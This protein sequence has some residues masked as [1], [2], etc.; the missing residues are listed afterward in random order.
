M[1]LFRMFSKHISVLLTK[2]NITF[3]KRLITVIVALIVIAIIFALLIPM[4]YSPPTKTYKAK[5]VAF[6]A[7]TSFQPIAGLELV[8]SFNVTVQNIGKNDID[9]A[10]V[11]VQR[12]TNGTDTLV[13]WVY[14]DNN[15]I[16]LRFNETK[17]IRTTLLVSLDH[18]D[19]VA[20]SNFIAS[21]RLNETILDE[22]KLF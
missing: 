11:T 16:D 9:L 18:Y 21:I 10:N 2:T 3:S 13:G 22:R 6:T 5:I 12:I 1:L 4:W 20:R 15:T 14:L 17:L 19:E 7:D 8:M